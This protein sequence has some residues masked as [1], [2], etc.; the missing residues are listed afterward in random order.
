[1]NGKLGLRGNH[2][3]LAFSL[4][5]RLP[6]LMRS[7]SVEEIPQLGRDVP[8]NVKCFDRQDNTESKHFERGD[9]PAQYPDSRDQ[10][11]EQAKWTVPPCSMILA[12]RAPDIGR[13]A[14]RTWFNEAHTPHSPPPVFDLFILPTKAVSVTTVSFVCLSYL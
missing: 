2:T 5:V 13:A 8:E 14:K 4:G 9:E 10:P 7:T 3:F 11:S 1:M 6:A 12:A